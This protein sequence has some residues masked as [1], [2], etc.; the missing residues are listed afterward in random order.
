MGILWRPMR[1][2]DVRGCADIVAAHPVNG[3]RYGDQIIHL[4]KVWL[5]LLGREAFR[6]VVFE[7]VNGSRPPEPIGVGVSAFVSDAFLLELK[8]P[9]FGWIG[10]ELVRRIV[11]GNDPLLS[12]KQVRQ[13]KDR[14]SVV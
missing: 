14:K 11:E 8:T 7:S 5:S 6:A 9:P 10:P 1:P 12:D 13:A 4:S 2:K 3:A